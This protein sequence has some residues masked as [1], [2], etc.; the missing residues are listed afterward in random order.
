MSVTKPAKLRK[1][2]LSSGIGFIAGVGGVMG[3]YALGVDVEWSGGRVAAGGVGVIYLMTGLFVLLGVAVP[4]VGA[5]LLNVSDVEELVE[6]RA[7]LMGSALS[8]ITLGVMLLCLAAAGPGGLIP[9]AVA[10]AAVAVALLTSVVVYARQWRLYDE[11][12]QQLSWES[13]AFATTLILPVLILWGGAVQLGY[14]RSMDPLAVIA[15]AAGS[16]LAGAVIATGRRG[17]LA[18]R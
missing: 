8:V 1:M 11:L 13:S 4:G 3:F 17:L 12:W 10:I 14:V 7:I 9:D 16:I 6:Q 5:K 2:M 15:L 18:P